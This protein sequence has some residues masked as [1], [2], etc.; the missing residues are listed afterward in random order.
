[1]T[2]ND[3]RD[4]RA[5]MHGRPWFAANEVL[6]FVLELVAIGALARWGFTA[7]D[8]WATTL[9]LGLGTPAA[10][11]ALWGLFAA[12]RARIRLPLPGVLAVKTLVLGGAA[13]AVFGTGHPVAAVV[14]AVVMAVN[15]GCA[16]Y[17][18]RGA[19]QD[20]TT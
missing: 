15:T 20:V 1:M 14:L 6:A 16:E 4:P 2:V 3:G 5:A 12:P 9:L 10:A 13:A 7:V 19:G 11:V 8:G 17:F 18:R